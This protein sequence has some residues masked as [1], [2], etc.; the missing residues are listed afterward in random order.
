MAFR[1]AGP[2]DGITGSP[3]VVAARY[4]LRTTADLADRLRGLLQH[5]GTTDGPDTAPPVTADDLLT[6]H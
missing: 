4:E 2:R 5:S 1:V 6:R 3:T